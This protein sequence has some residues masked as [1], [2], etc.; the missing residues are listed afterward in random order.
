MSWFS[1]SSKSTATNSQKIKGGGVLPQGEWKRVSQLLS[2]QGVQYRKDDALRF[3]RLAIIAERE[4]RPFG[5]LIEPEPNNQNDENA[6]K[7]LGWCGSKTIHIGYVDR[8][9]AAR[10]SERYPGIFAAADFYSIYLSASQYIDIRFFLCVPEKILP[11]PSSRVHKLFE[12]VKDEL[13]VLLFVAKADG[14]LGRFENDILNRY[15]AER[16][17]DFQIPLVDEDVS[18]IRKWL[19]EQSPQS[20]EI[21][22][23]ID[24]IADS[25]ILSA[26]ELWELIELVVSIDGKISKSEKA[27]ALEIAQYIKNS[28]GF[29]P[30]NIG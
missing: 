19:K 21:S 15:A 20:D 28:F 3:V 24:R 4:L 29:D 1:G 14:K 5:L 10:F 18:D 11:Q 22:A 30:M 25:N 6:L 16:A 12:F 13:L 2:T 8:L 23:V 26:G 27:V 7:V 17:N 9:E